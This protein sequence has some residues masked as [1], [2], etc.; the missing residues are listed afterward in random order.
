MNPMLKLT[1]VLLFGLAACATPQGGTLEQPMEM[2]YMATADGCVVGAG[3]VGT[4]ADASFTHSAKYCRDAHGNWREMTSGGNFG[5]TVSGQVAVALAG[6]VPAALIQGA[7]G[8]A[9]A[10][11]N[12]CDGDC[13]NIVLNNGAMAASQSGAT[14]T[15]TGN[16]NASSGGC[17]ECAIL[18]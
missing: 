6:T 18:N 4:S 1:P 16:A 13:G 7:A 2:R 8:I 3:T 9:I 15:G 12:G 5:P 17:P 14:A 11:E 10:R